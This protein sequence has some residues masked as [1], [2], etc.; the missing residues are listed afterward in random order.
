MSKK[1]ISRILQYLITCILYLIF[2]VYPALEV[3]VYGRVSLDLQVNPTLLNGLFAASSILFGFSS[4]LTIRQGRIK[5]K[6]WVLISIP[7]FLTIYGGMAITRL[8]LG[9]Q[10]DVEALVLVSASF[11]ANVMTAVWVFAEHFPSES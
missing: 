7:L 9:L 8:G 2:I 11:N 1:R 5:K 3:Y 4:L 10:K 6:F